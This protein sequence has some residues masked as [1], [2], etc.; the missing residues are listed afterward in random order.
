V[1]V[2]LVHVECSTPAAKEVVRRLVEIVEIA[3]IDECAEA[4]CSRRLCGLRW[5][6]CRLGRLLGPRPGKRRD[7]QGCGEGAGSQRSA[8]GIDLRPTGYSRPSEDGVR[9]GQ[10]SRRF[11][12]VKK[13]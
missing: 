4:P 2:E 8:H 13:A 9:M 1:E 6:L 11:G 7:G 3:E 10:Q 5:R 12:G